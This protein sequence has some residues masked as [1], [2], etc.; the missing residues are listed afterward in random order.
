MVWRLVNYWYTLENEMR[1]K[2][3]SYGNACFNISI[4]KFAKWPKYINGKRIQALIWSGS[5]IINDF[6]ICL[7]GVLPHFQHC[8]GHITTGSWKGIGNQYTQLVKILYCK[9]PTNGKQLPAFPLEAVPGTE[10]RPQRWEV[11]VL[12]LCH[13]GPQR[14]YKENLKNVTSQKVVKGLVVFFYFLLGI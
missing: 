2:L 1:L 11:R 10:P 8:T 6:I 5:L 7:Y 4:S 3:S 12:P 9:L 13:R 14:L